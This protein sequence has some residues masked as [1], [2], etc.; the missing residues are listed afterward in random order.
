MATQAALTYAASVTGG[1]RV[2]FPAGRYYLGTGYSDGTAA[3][4][5]QLLLGSRTTANAASNIIIEGWGAKIYPGAPGRALMLANCNN[6]SIQGLTFIGYAGGTLGASREFDQLVSLGYSSKH[7]ELRSC[8]LT[9]CL[10]WTIEGTADPTAAGGG[11]GNTLF[12]IRILDC[13]IKQRYGDGIASS[14]SGSMSQRAS[15][16]AVVVLPAPCR[17]ASSTTTGG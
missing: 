9:N 10:G 14:S 17:P 4:V 15:F 6:V 3:V 13:I 2:V 8:Y 11:T 12:D 16:A 1:C 7:I 5:A